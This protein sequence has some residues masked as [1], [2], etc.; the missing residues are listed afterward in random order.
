MKTNIEGSTGFD[1]FQ[2]NPHTNLPSAATHCFEHKSGNETTSSFHD[3]FYKHCSVRDFS[4][5]RIQ[6][7]SG[8]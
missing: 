1:P 8:E 5:V 4:N 3:C 7:T 2:H 6:V